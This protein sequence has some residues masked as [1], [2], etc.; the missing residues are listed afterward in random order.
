MGDRNDIPTIADLVDRHYAVLYRYAF[1]LAGNAADA[2]DTTQQAFLTAQR[3]L[4]QLREPDYAR[5]WLFTIVR[6]TFLKTVRSQPATPPVSL[7]AVGEPETPDDNDFSVDAELLQ[8]ALNEL[9]E[10]FRTPLILYYFKDFSYKDIARQMDL[11][12]GTVMSRLA[13]GKTILRRK[14]AG[15]EAS[16]IPANQSEAGSNTGSG[17]A[18]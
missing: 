18:E 2:E 10:E 5:A 15:T 14:L 3:K 9:S 12:L 16:M 8:S 4:D 17:E 7:E 6:N 1:R 13:R 11:P